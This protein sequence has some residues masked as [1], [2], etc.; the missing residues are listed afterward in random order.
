MTVKSVVKLIEAIAMKNG[1]R[2][3]AALLACMILAPPSFASCGMT[4][5]GAPGERAALSQ[6]IYGKAYDGM[7]KNISPL[8]IRYWFGDQVTVSLRPE[9]HARK[10]VF[11]ALGMDEYPIYQDVIA[12]PPFTTTWPQREEDAFLITGVQAEIF[13]LDGKPITVGYEVDRRAA[14]N[15]YLQQFADRGFYYTPACP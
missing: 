13:P 10:V 5:P 1:I 6:L 8:N 3:A 7:N 9:I 4:I 2:L 12:K 15:E 11:R 14:E